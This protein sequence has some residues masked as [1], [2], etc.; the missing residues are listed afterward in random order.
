MCIDKWKEA[1]LCKESYRYIDMDHINDTPSSQGPERIVRKLSFSSFFMFI[2]R[3][4]LKEMSKT[5]FFIVFIMLLI[6]KRQKHD[7]INFFSVCVIRSEK[8]KHDG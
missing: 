2:T 8:K 7:K 6:K 3:Y 1:V 5:I 4:K